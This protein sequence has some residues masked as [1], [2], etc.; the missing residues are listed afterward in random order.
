M[1]RLGGITYS[2]Q[3]ETLEV[4]RPS[5]VE[6]LGGLEGAAKLEKKELPN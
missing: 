6:D 2:R 3:L 4:P 1:A 5:F